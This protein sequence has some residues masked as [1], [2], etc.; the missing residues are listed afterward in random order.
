MSRHVSD[1][2]SMD[3]TS[4]SPLVV[5]LGYRH[6]QA[7]GR[8][9]HSGRATRSSSPR[10]LRM[11]ERKRKLSGSGVQDDR[12]AKRLNTDANLSEQGGMEV[13]EIDEATKE[14][15]EVKEELSKSKEDFRAALQEI[16][17]L[18]SLIQVLRATNEQL[19]NH[20]RMLQD[21]VDQFNKYADQ[22]LPERE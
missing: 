22:F 6:F 19:R 21:L 17:E 5:T 10:P 3:E 2:V 14:L 12:F 11:G 1:Q 8:A 4:D 9:T 15:N 13:T 16:G 7:C 20:S 18:H